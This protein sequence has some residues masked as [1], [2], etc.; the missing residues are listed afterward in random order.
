VRD[1]PAVG[2]PDLVD[3]DL[4]VVVDLVAVVVVCLDERVQAHAVQ[5]GR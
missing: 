2:G 1:R 5:P 4:Y 3:V